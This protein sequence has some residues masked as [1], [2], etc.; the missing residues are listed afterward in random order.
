MERIILQVYPVVTKD[1]TIQIP[2]LPHDNSE[3]A[4]SPPR[5]QPSDNR[6]GPRTGPRERYGDKRSSNTRRTGLSHEAHDRERDING[7]FLPKINE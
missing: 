2:T 5:Q 6:T 3:T 7:R 1:G 4:E